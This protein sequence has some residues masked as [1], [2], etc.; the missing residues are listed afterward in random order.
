MSV[1]K[2]STAGAAKGDAAADRMRALL[3]YT[4]PVVHVDHTHRVVAATGFT[5][6]EHAGRVHNLYAVGETVVYTHAQRAPN[7]MKATVL[8]V[9]DLDRNGLPDGYYVRLEDGQLA[10]TSEDHLM[11]YVHGAARVPTTPAR[12]QATATMKK[13]QTYAIVVRR[14]CGLK[15]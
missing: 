4:G 9:Y 11:P 13:G 10:D 3:T 8:K 1:R 14:A 2:S 7:G 15:H 6:V 12:A 5:P